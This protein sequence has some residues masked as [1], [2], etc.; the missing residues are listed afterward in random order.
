LIRAADQHK[1]Q[2]CTQPYGK[3]ADIITEDDPAALVGMNKNQN[4]PALVEENADLAAEA[5][6]QAREDAV[7]AASNPD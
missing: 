6:E 4:V 7:H 5:A 2:E 1:C 3:T